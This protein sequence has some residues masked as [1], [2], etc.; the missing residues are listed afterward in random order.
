MGIVLSSYEYE[1]WQKIYYCGFKKKCRLKED[2]KE[3]LNR[4][5]EKK[6]TPLKNLQSGG[7]T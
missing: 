7:L 4:R 1:M 2:L 6:M 5:F 3:L